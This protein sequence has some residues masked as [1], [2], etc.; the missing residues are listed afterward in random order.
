MDSLK[1][2]FN[3]MYPFIYSF[4]ILSCRMVCHN[5]DIGNK[6]LKGH[7]AISVG[8]ASTRQPEVT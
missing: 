4:R 7:S 8:R 1:T 2:V 3:F 5:H 6:T